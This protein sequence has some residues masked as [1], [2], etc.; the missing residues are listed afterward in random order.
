MDL[1]LLFDDTTLELDLSVSASLGGL[2][3]E[4][5][6]DLDARTI[7]GLE[8]EHASGLRLLVG[9]TT[10]EEG[11]RV[12]GAHVRAA[13]LALKRQFLVT[14]IDCG[15]TFSEP[16]LAALDMADR[17]LVV[18]TPELLTLRDV[19]ECQRLFGQALHLEKNR[20]AYV[21]NHP[22]PTVG[23]TRRQFE[24]ALEQR[25]LLE[26]P[27]AGQGAEKP[28]FAKAIDQLVRELGT[29]AAKA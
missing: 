11:E 17:V 1:D 9:A 14:V 23:L 15:G 28:V 24:D 13:L 18:C 27:H 10:P 26:I 19:R 22:A 25:M 4:Q 12:T 8:V 29:T 2:A 3:G 21:F 6:Q 7:S 16:T 20:V 5:A